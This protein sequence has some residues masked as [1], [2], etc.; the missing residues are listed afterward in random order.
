VR[1]PFW[2]GLVAAIS[3]CESAPK[4]DPTS[5]RPQLLDTLKEF[6]FRVGSRSVPIGTLT[7]GVLADDFSDLLC[8]GQGPASELIHTH[9]RLRRLLYVFTVGRYGGRPHGDGEVKEQAS[10]RWFLAFLGLWLKNAEICNCPG[11]FD[12]SRWEW[13]KRYGE[14]ERPTRLERIVQSWDTANPPARRGGRTAPQTAT[15]PNHV[16]DRLHGVGR[17][18]G[19]SAVNRGA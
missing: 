8:F 5:D 18:A 1:N 7:S 2:I 19:E 9:S 3:A 11:A 12:L 4:R 17:R 6:L 13:F 14:S 10:D 15:R 16:G